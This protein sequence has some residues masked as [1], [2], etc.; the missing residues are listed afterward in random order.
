MKLAAI[1]PSDTGQ[2]LRTYNCPR[3]KRVERHVIESSV[4]AAWLAPKK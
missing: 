4:T 1:E 2:D 3:C